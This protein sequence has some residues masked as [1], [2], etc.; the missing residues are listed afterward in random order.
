MNN[1]PCL[2]VEAGKEKQIA[3]SKVYAGDIIK[4]ID[5]ETFPA[6][7]VLLSSS[8]KNMCYIETANLDGESNYKQRR[9]LTET[10]KFTTPEMCE[11]LKGSRITCGGPDNRLYEFEGTFHMPSTIAGDLTLQASLVG[12][13][14]SATSESSEDL[15]FPLGYV[16]YFTL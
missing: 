6:D 3:T 11:K 15:K 7:L 14:T 10:T 13:D 8:S 9:A 1:K 16:F 5:G 2:L 12:G 4:V